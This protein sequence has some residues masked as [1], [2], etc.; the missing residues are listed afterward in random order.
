MSGTADCQL[1][2]TF[3]QSLTEVFK[4]SHVSTPRFPISVANRKVR[5]FTRWRNYGKMVIWL[6]WCH[7]LRSPLPWTTWTIPRHNTSSNWES[8]RR[9]GARSP[10]SPMEQIGFRLPSNL[11]S[12]KVPLLGRNIFT[13]DIYGSHMTILSHSYVNIYAKGN[14]WGKCGVLRISIQP[15]E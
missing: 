11:S 14:H 4:T 7:H 2:T 13:M 12:E 1:Q 15:M 3:Y 10:L 6:Y 9:Y 5:T 8:K